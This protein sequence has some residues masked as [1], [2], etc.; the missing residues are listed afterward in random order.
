MVVITGASAGVG[1]ATA[2][3]FARQGASLGLIARSEGGL[4]ETAAEVESL[5]GRALPIP[6]DV[7]DA[8]AVDRAAQ[9]VETELGAIDV[10]VNNAMVSVLAP[11]ADT[12]SEEFRR[13]TEV[14]YLGTVHGTQAALRRMRPRDRGVIVQ[15]G[16]ALAYRAIPYQAAY[17]ATKHAIEGFTESLRC[18]LLHDGSN[19]RVTMVQL[20]ALNTP[21]FDWLRNRLPHRAQPVPPVFQPELAGRAIRYAA[22]HPR[23]ELLVGGSTVLAV[24]ADK[25]AP[26]LADLYLAW[27]GYR[28]QQGDEPEDRDR[29]DNLF[30]PTHGGYATHGRFDDQASESSTQFWLNTHRPQLVWGIAAAAGLLLIATRSTRRS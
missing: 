15:V 3:E 19:V 20:P 29:P 17:C 23:R 27:S 22:L 25:I 28:A 13:V 16:S 30:T 11:V 2:H 8:A 5:G 7:A 14:N 12:A 6:A 24:L 18:E 10:W 21:Q 9:L 4:A 26:G 1:R